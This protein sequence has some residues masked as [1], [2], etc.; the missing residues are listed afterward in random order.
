M[1]TKIRNTHTKLDPQE[2]IY[3]LKTNYEDLR[4]GEYDL[5]V[6][7]YFRRKD[8]HGKIQISMGFPSNY[9]EFWKLVRMHAMVHG[10]I[11]EKYDFS[12][13]HFGLINN[14][15]TEE[16]INFWEKDSP[17]VFKG[18]VT[19]NRAIFHSTVAIVNWEFQGYAF[20]YNCSFYKFL[21][22]TKCEFY[23]GFHLNRVPET[24]N[25]RFSRNLCDGV[26]RLVK[27]P[28]NQNN[29]E[30][31]IVSPKGS[32]YIDISENK[33]SLNFVFKKVNFHKANLS[34]SVIDKWIFQDC[35]WSNS[36]RLKL[37]GGSESLYRIIKRKLEDSKDWANAGKAFRS[38]M[39]TK[40]W[41]I[42]KSIHISKS[43]RTW[44]NPFIAF[45][46]TLIYAIYGVLSGYTQSILKPI[47]WLVLFTGWIFPYIYVYV[48]SN[49]TTINEELIIASV[50]NSMPF[51]KFNL[52]DEVFW[53]ALT[54]KIL[55]GTLLAFFVLALRKRF[56]Q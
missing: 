43:P 55:S 19:F 23:G 3:F 50:K 39:W 12:E 8:R 49:L 25:F 54:Q 28:S 53:W 26:I 9:K 40:Q 15:N 47:I 22:I 7:R 38:E 13:F 16:G 51:Y 35:F 36:H 48:D 1:S 33:S 42:L 10:Q 2:I 4:D 29:A 56:K 18:D 20:F 41:N 27:I 44:L 46:E 45:L 31:S 32:Y 30:L 6:K 21:T 37:K 24:G 5:L 17:K 14:L 34:N 52:G 11:N